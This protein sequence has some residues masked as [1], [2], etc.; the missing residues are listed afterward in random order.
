[1]YIQNSRRDGDWI[2]RHL[3]GISNLVHGAL[4]EP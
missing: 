3:D 4:V 2:R 1:V